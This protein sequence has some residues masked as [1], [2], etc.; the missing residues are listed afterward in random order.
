LLVTV[1]LSQ[2]MALQ[3][4]NPNP[5]TKVHGGLDLVQNPGLCLP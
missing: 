3:I 4:A 1:R 2:S 5:C